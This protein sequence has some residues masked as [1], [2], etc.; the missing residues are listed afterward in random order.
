VN[1]IVRLGADWG[2]RPWLL[3]GQIAMGLVR[4]REQWQVTVLLAPVS[5]TANVRRG[6]R[7]TIS[8]AVDP[9]QQRREWVVSPSGPYFWAQVKLPGRAFDDIRG[10]D[11]INL[12]FATDGAVPDED[13]LS[14]VSFL[15]NGPTLAAE[16]NLPVAAMNQTYEGDAPGV[17]LLLRRTA[18]R[19]VVFDL[20]RS[21]DGWSVASYAEME[22][23]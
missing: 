5:T 23:D 20:K 18:S 11:D 8:A 7:F 2:G 4:G 21:F 19:T 16:R 17:R 6:E 10:D 13:L 3:D 12:P 22:R 15:R 14:V 1:A 9:E